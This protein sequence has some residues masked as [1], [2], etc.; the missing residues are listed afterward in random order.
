MRGGGDPQQRSNVMRARA[1]LA[2]PFSVPYPT[3][4][5]RKFESIHIDNNRGTPPGFGAKDAP[6]SPQRRFIRAVPHQG[7]AQTQSGCSSVR[8]G[9]PAYRSS[10]GSLPHQGAELTPPEY[11]VNPTGVR[12]NF[13]RTGRTVMSASQAGPW[14]VKTMLC[15]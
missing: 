13:K 9:I 10:D 3:R 11:G 14:L 6:V 12:R 8:N 15:G 5:R 1:I 4:V 2:S 7:S